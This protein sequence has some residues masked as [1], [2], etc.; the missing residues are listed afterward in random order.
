MKTKLLMIAFLMPTL[1]FAQGNDWMNFFSQGYEIWGNFA[2]SITALVAAIT[3]GTELLKAALKVEGVTA[4]VISWGLGSVL[5]ILG[6]IIGVG[7]FIEATWLWTSLIAAGSTLVANGV[8]TYD[9]MKIILDFI[10][11]KLHKVKKDEQ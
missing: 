11:P 6:K 5:A 9:F 3:A 10:T 7:I 4:K 1:I 8:F 2:L